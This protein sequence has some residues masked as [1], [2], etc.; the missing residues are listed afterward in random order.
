MQPTLKSNPK[1]KPKIQTHDKL[2]IKSPVLTSNIKKPSSHWQK[3]IQF[4]L[5]ISRKLDSHWQYQENTVLT[6][7]IKNPIYIGTILSKAQ[8][9]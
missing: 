1:A 9:Y 8:D 5:A 7:N 4:S 3:K 2:F 6:D